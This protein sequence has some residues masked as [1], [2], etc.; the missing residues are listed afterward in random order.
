MTRVIFLAGEL[1]DTV[2]EQHA[3]T[4]RE[5]PNC[6]YLFHKDGHQLKDFRK[7]WDRALR[8]AGYKPT[9]RVVTDQ[10]LRL[11]N[12]TILRLCRGTRLGVE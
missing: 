1:Y 12:P 7:A 9:F 10:S 11:I 8:H 3:K 4:S 2:L 5:Y 6:P